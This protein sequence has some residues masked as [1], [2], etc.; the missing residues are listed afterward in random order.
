VHRIGRTARA[1]ASGIAISLCDAGERAYIRDIEKLTKQ[2]FVLEAA[3]M[4]ERTSAPHHHPNKSRQEPSHRGRPQRG[5]WRHQQ[6]R[7]AA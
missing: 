6:R 1:G 2:Q 5:R 7:R 4:P 3:G